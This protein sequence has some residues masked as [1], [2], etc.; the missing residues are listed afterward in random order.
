MLQLSLQSFSTRDQSYRATLADLGRSQRLVFD[1]VR[2]SDWGLTR[3]EIAF[4]C[5]LKESSVCGRV[6]ELLG[7]GLVV[8]RGVRWDPRTSRNQEIIVSVI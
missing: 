4:A 6:K 7:F 2:R 3:Q 1:A 8:V 5:G